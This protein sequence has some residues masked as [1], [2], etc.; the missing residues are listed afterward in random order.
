MLAGSAAG[1]RGTGAHNRVTSHGKTR[2]TLALEPKNTR[3]PGCNVSTAGDDFN[4]GAA[5]RGP[6]QSPAAA[7]AAPPGPSLVTV[8]TSH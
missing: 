2:R 1:C 8:V 7:A 3:D 5:G 6:R 4:E